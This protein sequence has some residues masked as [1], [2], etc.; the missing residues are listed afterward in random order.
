M[1]FAINEPRIEFYTSQNENF[2]YLLFHRKKKK[3]KLRQEFGVNFLK[4]F[5]NPLKFEF[6]KESNCY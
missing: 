3:D 4:C 2:I 6:E 1:G 5:P